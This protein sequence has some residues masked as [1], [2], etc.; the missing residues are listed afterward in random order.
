MKVGFMGLPA[1]G[2]TT[3][4]DALT[5]LHRQVGFAG[6]RR[7]ADTAAVR[8][9]DE[10]LDRLCA[11]F[12]PK[13][14][15]PAQVLI[16]DIPGIHPESGP[17]KPADSA[18]RA[19]LLGAL[20]ESEAIL[21][22]LRAFRNE[23]VPHIHGAIDP[24]RDLEE[25]D[26]IILLSD[27]DLVERRIE[28]LRVSVTK[29]TKTQEKEKE[30]L[31]ILGKIHP[32]LSEGKPISTVDL[33]AEEEKQLRGFQ[34]LTQKLRLVVV[35]IDEN[36]SP[37]DPAFAPLKRKV[38]EPIFIKGQLE[39]ELGQLDEADR[40]AFMQDMGIETPASERLLKSCHALLNLRTFFTVVSEE[41]RA[42]TITAGDTALIAAGKIHTD[43]EHGFIR[44][45]V[46]HY[47]DLIACGGSVKE[48]KAKNLLRLKGKEYVVQDGDILTIRF[49]A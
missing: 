3:I 37:E 30:E 28:K 42:W 23:S 44:A 6:A 1:S 29:P 25:I 24:L 9:P 26:V 19:E 43:L 10:R 16:V 20:R 31:R 49:S 48:V 2:K 17:L 39:M 13:K 12:N 35:N 47:K 5:G 38:A 22:V 18:S 41:L 27:L 46:M 21:V 36:Q 15:T 45:E 11:I 33:N 4:F 32:A 8:V 40:K 14:R 34:F 7:D